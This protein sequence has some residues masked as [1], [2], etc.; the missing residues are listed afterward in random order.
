MSDLPKKQVGDW[1][2]T[3]MP[4]TPFTIE[5]FS[6]NDPHPE[7]WP[8]LHQPFD[9]ATGLAWPDEAT[10][11]KWVI[12]QINEHYMAPQ[13]KSEFHPDNVAKSTKE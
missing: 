7:G 11:E 4:S 6:A 10:A 8:V 12:D 3:I 9:P 2:Y 13:D 1:L 5:V